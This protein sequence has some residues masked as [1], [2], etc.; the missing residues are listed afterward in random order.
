MRTPR[1]AARQ[2]AAISAAVWWPAATWLNRSRSMAARRAAVRWKALAVSKNGAG[3]GPGGGIGAPADG[4]PR[5]GPTRR[6]PPA[7]ILY[8]G[9]GRPVPRPAAG[10]AVPEMPPGR[11][12]RGLARVNLAAPPASYHFG[13]PP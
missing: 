5:A 12:P 3:F 11:R 7:V 10:R 2:A 1:G 13:V 4:R 9:D 8:A 6:P